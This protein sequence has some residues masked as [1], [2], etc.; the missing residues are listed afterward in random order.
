MQTT[1]A[2]PN[3]KPLL[4]IAARDTGGSRRVAQF[5]LSLWDGDTYRCDVQAVMYL[6][7]PVFDDLLGLWRFLYNTNTQLST[8]VSTDQMAPIID[9]WGAAFRVRPNDGD[10]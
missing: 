1:L 7:A 10:R 5:L 9:A 6:D 4:E 2:K 3:L 8:H